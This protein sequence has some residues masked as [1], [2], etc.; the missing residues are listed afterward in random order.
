V[1]RTDAV[2][3][4]EQGVTNQQRIIKTKTGILERLLKIS[5]MS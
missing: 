3:G 5:I 1:E 4:K 2:L